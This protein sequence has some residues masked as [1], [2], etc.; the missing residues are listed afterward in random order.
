MQN[1]V[2]FYGLVMLLQKH[3][4]FW[5]VLWNIFWKIQWLFIIKL[6]ITGQIEN[7][8]IDLDL[9][10]LDQC[11]WVEKI[12]YYYRYSEI[13]DFN[14]F[15]LLESYC[16]YFVYNGILSQSMNLHL[17]QHSK[18]FLMKQ[19]LIEK[20]LLCKIIDDTIVTWEWGWDFSWKSLLWNF[21]HHLHHHPAGLALL[22]LLLR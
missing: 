13:S 19:Q 10:A 1:L 6:Y 8:T 11:K 5:A 12:W 7:N 16:W 2:N 21:I 14:Q 3:C 17:P 22:L 18:I 15:K 20:L 4:W 9:D